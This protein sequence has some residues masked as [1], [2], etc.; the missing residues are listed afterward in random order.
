MK[1]LVVADGHYYIDKDKNVFVESVF[2]YSFYARYLSAFEDVFAI[3]RAENVESAPKGCK[4]ASGPNVHFLPIPPSKGIKQYALN[5]FENQK[6]IK[7][8]VKDFECAIFRIPG[9]VANTVMPIFAKT[10]K[11][12]AIEVVVDPWEYFAKGTVQGITRPFVQRGWTQS[13][14][15]ACMSANGVAYVTQHYLQEK[16]PCR[17]IVNPG[18]SYFTG[19]YSSVELPDDKF[20]FS[21]E[22]QKKEKYIISHVANAFTGYGKGHIT[23]MKASKEVLERGYDIDVWFVGDGPLRGEFENKAKELGIADHIKFLGRMPSGDAVRERIKE[24]DLFVFP[25][26]AEGLP[27]VIL[28][29]MAEGI[30]AISSPVC[31]IPEILPKECLV[32]YDDYKGYAEVIIRMLDD[33]GLMTECSIRNLEESRKYKSSILNAKRR[34]FYIK[35]KEIAGKDER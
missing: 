28:E 29:A 14:K 35:L 13:L 24:S 15:R 32:D 3:V 4:K 18:E 2:D 10:G 23:L 27:R 6:L 11:P 30:P 19:S 31:G 20:G 22:Y 5:Y 34:E 8:Y 17:A 25:T 1:L 33:P 12:Y 7:E 26:R 21:K 9:V 16:Y